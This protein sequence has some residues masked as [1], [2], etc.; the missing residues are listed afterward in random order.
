MRIDSWLV[1][2]GYFESRQRAQLAIKSGQVWC[3]GEKVRRPS[4]V[5]QPEEAIE[6]KGSPLPYVSLGGLKLEKA[7]HEFH[8]DFAHKRVLDAGASTGGFTDCAL[9]H[10]AAKVYAVDV[11]SG[12]LAHSL[13]T[14][15]HVVFYENFDVRQL[16]LEKL[17]G[18]KV[19]AIVCD[20][21]FISLTNVLPV[22]PALL[23]PD[24]FI[25]LLIKPQFEMEQRM[26]LKGG[27][28]KNPAMR[29]QAVQRV[30]ACAQSLGFQLLGLT[31]TE[32]DTQKKNLEFLVW[33]KH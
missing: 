24:G 5:V 1:Q 17:D 16:T 15:P 2:Q 28:V 18:E 32:V 11:G 7:I 14:H 9:Q 26:T 30:I 29:Q 22:F 10:G 33:M 13:R 8:L 12:Q 20:V 25:L 19:D 3:K 27:I 4:H 23:K 21:S 6:V 31:E